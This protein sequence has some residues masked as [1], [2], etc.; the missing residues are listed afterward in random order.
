MNRREVILKLSG[1]TGLPMLLGACNMEDVRQKEAALGDRMKHPG[2]GVQFSGVPEV[3]KILATFPAS[4]QQLQVA[5]QRAH[6]AAVILAKRHVATAPPQKRS[7]VVQ[8]DVTKM[9]NAQIAAAATAQ[10]KAS[11]GTDNVAIEVP[12]DSRS[13]GSAAYMLY[14]LPTQKFVG[15]DSVYDISSPPPKGQVTAWG[16]TSALT[17]GAGNAF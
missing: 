3:I 1:A 8:N 12:R 15:N 10:A 11:A 4:H 5:T 17:L 7:V 9:N 16:N 13:K 6:Q 14:N 2:T